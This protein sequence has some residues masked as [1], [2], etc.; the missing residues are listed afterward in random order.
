M[1]GCVWAWELGSA[2]W[3][4]WA[5]KDR[6]TAGRGFKLNNLSNRLEVEKGKNYMSIIYEKW[7]EGDS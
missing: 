6:E 2:L 1:G 7:A 3:S 4:A 5:L